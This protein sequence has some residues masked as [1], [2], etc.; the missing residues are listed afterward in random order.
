MPSGPRTAE[1]E[2]AA[3]PTMKRMTLAVWLA[4]GAAL[5]PPHGLA[6]ADFEAGVRAYD[7]CDV[8]AAI[9]TFRPLAEAGDAAAA[10]NLGVIHSRGEA[11]GDGLAAAARSCR[12]AA[13]TGAPAPRNR[14]GPK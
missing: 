2:G 12:G 4:M 14:H 1:V 5:A 8:A 10:Y 9:A 6:R 3:R 13:D 7:Q 11:G